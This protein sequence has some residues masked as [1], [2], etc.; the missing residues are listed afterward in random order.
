MGT[1]REKALFLAV[2]LMIPHLFIAGCVSNTH[3]PTPSSA[4]ISQQDLRAASVRQKEIREV[5]VVALDYQAS[6]YAMSA[7]EAKGTL[8]DEL[9]ASPWVVVTKTKDVLTAEEWEQRTSLFHDLPRLITLAHNRGLDGLVM[10]EVKDLQVESTVVKVRDET[11]FETTT[12][13]S[14][15]GIANLRIQAFD[16]VDN[17]SLLSTTV[18]GHASD[19][20]TGIEKQSELFASSAKDG[21][22]KVS[23][24]VALAFKPVPEVVEVR[25]NGQYVKVNAGS[26]SGISRE[27]FLEIQTF[28]P[29]KDSAGRVVTQEARRVCAVPVIQV[30]PDSCWCDGTIARGKILIGHMAVPTP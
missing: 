9:R 26:N 7:A 10:I 30:A 4:P 14:R 18:A 16:T 5:S 25:G 24:E 8:A 17:I 15:H 11:T 6:D 2:A 12:T 29:I 23:R 27:M 20:T 22:L 28:F 1:A 3:L 13:T 19:S 21:M